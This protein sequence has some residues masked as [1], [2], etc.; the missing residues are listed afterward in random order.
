MP[1]KVVDG[2]QRQPR[3]EGQ[4]LG[5]VHPHQKGPDKPG[6][7]GYGYSGDIG[8]R[9]LCFA[10]GTV[11][12]GGYGLAMP[13]GGYLRHHA[14]VY[15]VLLYLACHHRREHPAAVLNHRRGGLVAGGLYS[16]YQ[17]GM[18][19]FCSKSRVYISPSSRGF[20]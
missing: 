9:D 15:P 11:Y 4:A 14:A 8:K 5:K 10:E 7:I 18:S 12:N 2:H 6:G 17:H 20:S 16:Q 19:S 3:R 13:A 1:P